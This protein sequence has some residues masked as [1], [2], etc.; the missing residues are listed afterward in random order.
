MAEG[1][2]SGPGHAA[3]NDKASVGYQ[4]GRGD[5]E[6]A[7]TCSGLRMMNRQ[8]RGVRQMVFDIV[9]KCRC[10][11]CYLRVAC[12]SKHLIPFGKYRIKVT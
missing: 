3:S 1:Y 4:S 6:H 12:W 8:L 5:R 10:S 9:R 11:R 7:G 2:L